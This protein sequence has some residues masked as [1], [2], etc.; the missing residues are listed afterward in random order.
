MQLTLYYRLSTR[1]KRAL[2]RTKNLRSRRNALGSPYVYNPRG[3]LLERL[4]REVGMSID[5]VYFQLLKE[6]AYIISLEGGLP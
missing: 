3:P 6:R 5:D 1:S 4:S 2:A